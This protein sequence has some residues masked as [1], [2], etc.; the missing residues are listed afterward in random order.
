MSDDDL[1]PDFYY[2][3]SGKSISLDEM[4]RLKF[5]TPG[6]DTVGRTYIGG[7]EVST[8]WLGIDIIASRHGASRLFETA[9]FR[10]N[11]RGR[12][13]NS[14]WILRKYPTEEAAR[15]GHANACRMVHSGWRGENSR[16]HR[17]RMRW[18]AI[19]FLEFLEWLQ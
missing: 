2:D 19:V 9:I 10:C 5:A 15:R 7:W 4:S 17:R 12:V 13:R 6:Y 3:R 16:T 8:V 18:D 14:C 1:V 11:R